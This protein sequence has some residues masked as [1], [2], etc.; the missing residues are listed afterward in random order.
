MSKQSE[1]QEAAEHW[2]RDHENSIEFFDSFLPFEEVPDDAEDPKEWANDYGQEADGVVGF[3][4]QPVED[5]NGNG[6]VALIL[7]KGHSWEEIRLMV[8]G[9]YETKEAALRSID[10]LGYRL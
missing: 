8:G 10:E 7:G 9:V 6:G 4:L 1:L 5:D 3:R 2:L